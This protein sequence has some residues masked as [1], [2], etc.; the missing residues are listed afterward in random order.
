[1]RLIPYPL[2]RPFVLNAPFVES[3]KLKDHLFINTRSFASEKLKSTFA[4]E[5]YKGSFSFLAS[6]KVVF[7]ND[8]NVKTPYGKYSDITSSYFIYTGNGIV[9]ISSKK[10]LLDYFEPYKKEIKIYMKKDKMRFN[11]ANSKQWQGLMKII[12]DLIT[13]Y[14]K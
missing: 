10:A 4:N 1:M 11:K 9:K 12:D 13:A 14:A 5:V 8:Y 6:Y 2:L 3:F 7:V